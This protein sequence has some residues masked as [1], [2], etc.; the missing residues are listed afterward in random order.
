MKNYLQIQVRLGSEPAFKET[1][2]VKM[3]SFSGAYSEKYENKEVTHWFYFTAFGYV[4]ELCSQLKKGELVNI[5][6]KIQENSW[7]GD[8]GKKKSYTQI[9]VIGIS[10]PV[11]LEKNETSKA[12]NAQP[13]NSEENDLPF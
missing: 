11:F 2:N 4:A 5:E 12:E 10:K 7:T 8:D 3:C 1:Q 9:I 6:A 13:F